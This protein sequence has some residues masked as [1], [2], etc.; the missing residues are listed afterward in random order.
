MGKSNNQN[1]DQPNGL[2]DSVRTNNLNNQKR[3]KREKVK[4]FDKFKQ[5]KPFQLELFELEPES[6]EYSQSVELYD[7]IP[8]YIWGKVKRIDGEFLRTLRREFECRGR[9][10]DLTLM[11]ARIED[12]KENSKEYFP[13]QR[14]ELVEDALRKMMTERQSVMLDGEVGISFTI[15][16][17]Q[18]EL[19][20]KGHT[21][22]YDELKDAI[23]V[24]NGTDIILKDKT[25]EVEIAFSPIENYGFAGEGKETKTFVRFSPLVTHSIQS[26]SFRMFNYEKSM[27]FKSVIARQLHK[28][29]S[30][31][32]KQAGFTEVYEIL[33]TTIIRDFGLTKQKRLGDNLRDVAKS[34]KIMK[35]K[36]VIHSY[37]TEKIYQ[38][39]PRKKII[40]AKIT[41]HPHASFI[42]DI[43]K[44]NKNTK[45][46]E[47]SLKEDS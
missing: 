39:K 18:Q 34:L 29:M 3:R 35:E 15:Y 1:N 44:A 42:N 14:E 11:P 28:R 6:K 41:I 38:K 25:G 27:S 5:D 9:K 13:S 30:H 36:E 43:I 23:R 32:F 19:N 37:K 45:K 8:K 16:Q 12:G 20:D 26:G 33:L 22:S 10:Y 46:V 7:F 31:H 21:Y 40:D 47:K 17:L 2:T 4:N 24:L